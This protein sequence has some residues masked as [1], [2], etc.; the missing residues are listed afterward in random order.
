VKIS[1]IILILF[2]LASLNVSGQSISVTFGANG[3]QLPDTISVGDT[4][5]YS[6]W[7]VNSGGNILNDNISLKT[8][9]YSQFNGLTNE[10]SLG[11][12]ASNFIY[13]NDSI[14]FI[15]GFIYEVV[16]QQNFLLGDN[17][18]VI[19]PKVLSPLSQSTQYEYKNIY[20]QG[21]SM[22]SSVL[23]ISDQLKLFPIPADNEVIFDGD[24]NVIKAQI[25][26]V[27]GKEL[28]TYFIENNML[29]T[30]NFKNGIYLM[31]IQFKDGTS[32]QN[33]LK[34]QH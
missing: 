3:I 22:I 4:V 10:R 7:V 18:V 6:C 9:N 17:I 29:N 28:D 30:T 19:W 11:C 24:K 32:S 21:P 26:N 1:K 16:T 14:Q 34:I 23:D 25:F 20:V 12:L 13:P 31:N 27:L 5:Y 2:L 33:K 15:E 8:A